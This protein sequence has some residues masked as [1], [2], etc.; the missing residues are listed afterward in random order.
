MRM[1]DILDVG[2]E[3]RA[4]KKGIILSSQSLATWKDS[5]VVELRWTRHW[6]EIILGVGNEEFRVD[7]L[8]L[9]NKSPEMELRILFY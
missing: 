5:V 4:L 8:S 7:M 6:V 9:R 1:S 3:R 2:C